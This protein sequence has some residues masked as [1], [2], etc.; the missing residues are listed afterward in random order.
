MTS[1]VSPS[2]VGPL[3]STGGLPNTRAS[4]V[5]LTLLR[6]PVRISR[7]GLSMAA[8][9]NSQRPAGDYEGL[10]SRHRDGLVP[11]EFGGDKHA[12]GTAL[13]IERVSPDLRAKALWTGNEG[14]GRPISAAVSRWF[15]FH[16]ENGRW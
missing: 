10:Q 7:P 14:Q 12:S 6:V 8:C 9:D 4:V 13:E 5:S 15:W 11:D 16:G 2:D 1:A 3:N